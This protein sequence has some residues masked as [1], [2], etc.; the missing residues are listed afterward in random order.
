M[1]SS[2]PCALHGRTAT[3]AGHG[4]DLPISRWSP[5]EGRAVYRL[6]VPAKTPAA[7][8]GNHARGRD[9]FLMPQRRELWI[10]VVNHPRSE[11]QD[12][13]AYRS[14]TVGRA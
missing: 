11:M 4:T 14:A 3:T 2:A 10:I 7:R 5:P 6:A 8:L 9:H 13:H 1:T 12:H